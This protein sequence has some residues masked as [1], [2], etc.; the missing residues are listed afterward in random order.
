MDGEGETDDCNH[1][2]ILEER[3]QAFQ[4]LDREEL[5]RLRAASEDVMYDIVVFRGHGLGCGLLHE[6]HCVFDDG[7][8]VRGEMEV[9]PGE[10]VDD[11]VDLDDRRVD[12][13]HDQCS[14]SSAN[15]E[16]AGSQS[17]S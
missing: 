4:E 12:S 9:L 6:F 2:I 1:S 17:V 14:G 3:F 16:S 7:R 10:L 8:V 15:S 5:N 13:V 11:R